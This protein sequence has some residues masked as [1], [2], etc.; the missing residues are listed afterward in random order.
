MTDD[1]DEDEL[2][3]RVGQALQ[4]Y[5]VKEEKTDALDPI[6][7]GSRDNVTP[8]KADNIV[9]KD[10]YEAENIVT[11]S[12][13]NVTPSKEDN[14]DIVTPSKAN[15]I[16]PKDESRS[17]DNVTPSKADNIFTNDEYEVKKLVN[18]CYNDLDGSNKH[19]IKFKVDV[20]I[21]SGG[22][23]CQGDILRF[24]NGCLARYDLPPFLLPTHDVVFK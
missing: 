6:L 19:E 5:K 18:I 22:P 8:S 15:N 21:V 3:G 13:D 11:G 20:D 10:E 24:F 17:R 7:A 23:P 14:N 12:Q 9:M 16:V 4:K 2:K 1:I